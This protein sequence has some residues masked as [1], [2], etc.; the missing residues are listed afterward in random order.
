MTGRFAE[1]FAEDIEVINLRNIDIRGGCLGCLNCCYDYTCVYKGKDGYTEF[2]NTKVKPA[3]VLVFT[4]AIKDRY[5]S[6]LMKCYFDRTFFKGATPAMEGKQ[7][8]FII[9]G[10][11]R[12]IPN[13][14]QILEGFIEL[15]QA[16]VV[17]IITDE[18]EDSD[19]IDKGLQSMAVRLIR[20]AKAE[21]VKPGSFLVHGARKILR[22]M[23][24]GYGRII[25]PADHRYYKK[26]GFYDFPQKD[27]KTR[28]RNLMIM[29]LIKIPAFRKE[30]Y[31]RLEAE[32]IKPLKK[33]VETL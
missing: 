1:A 3:E 6:S 8:G 5:L 2:F 9:S 17:D 30:F 12:Q 22:D 25:R 4:G 23:T 18:A 32:M 21:Y 10:P 29:T 20:L 24:W 13:L 11:L 7:L 15:Q 27:Y 14:R 31:K 19:A 26:Q 33:V 16:N 28:F